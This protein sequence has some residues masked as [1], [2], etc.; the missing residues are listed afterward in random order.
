MN[1]VEFETFRFPIAADKIDHY[2]RISDG[3][4]NGIHVIQIVEMEQHLSQI[5][6]QFQA[7]HLRMI[8]AIGKHALRSNFTEFIANI[9]SNE[10]GTTEN[11]NNHAIETGTSAST[12]FQ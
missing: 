2:I 8:A 9:T 4:T 11:R 6:D 7:I 10:S 3:F 1:I 12:P 5:A